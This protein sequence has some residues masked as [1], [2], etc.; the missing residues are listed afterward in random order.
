MEA[1]VGS[2]PQ[3]VADGLDG[4]RI[5]TST[6]APES[7]GIDTASTKSSV[8]PLPEQLNIQTDLIRRRAITFD[9]PLSPTSRNDDRPN[10]SQ[11]TSNVNSNNATKSEPAFHNTFGREGDESL[12]PLRRT[13][14]EMLHPYLSFPPN[15][16]RN[17]V[18]L[19]HQ[20]DFD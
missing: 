10:T 9:T 3:F 11:S 16:G 4:L 7:Q 17:S 5:P 12:P 14:S 18:S 2:I 20:K 13:K 15:L 1:A 6:T 8:S 19:S